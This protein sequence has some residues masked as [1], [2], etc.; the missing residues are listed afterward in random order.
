MN[1][2]LKRVLIIIGIVFGVV[3]LTFG[4]LFLKL[5]HEMSGFS[6]METG[7]VEDNIFVVKDGFAN[8]FIIQDG[9]QYI[10]IDAGMDQKIITLELEKLGVNSN[11]VTALFLT[12]TDSDHIG[13]SALFSNAKLYVAKEEL[14]MING[15]K[16]KFVRM[17]SNPGN[18]MPRNDFIFLEDRE[19]VQVGNLK[20]QGILV[21]GHTTGMMAYLVNDKYLFTGDILCLNEG[22]I[23]PIPKFFDMDH[24][25]AVESMEIIR[26]IPA[27]EYIF[28]SHWGY[29]DNFQRAIGF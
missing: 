12:H 14:P 23:T 22:K 18:S 2:V 25:Q 15:E 11:N 29:T 6:P 20:I 21:P 28:T 13:G 27:A 3:I 26:R 24:T 1:K 8:F 19:V 7:R 5:N 10:V 4:G 16:T 17:F 9:T